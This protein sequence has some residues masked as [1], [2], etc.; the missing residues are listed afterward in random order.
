[1]QTQNPYSPPNSAATQE[2]SYGNPL[3]ARFSKQAVDRLYSRSCNVTSVASFT[4]II[5]LILLGQ[6]S[7]QLASSTRVDGFD[8]YIILFGFLGGFGAISAY[9]M[10]KR[11]RSGRIMGISCSSFALIL[12]PVGTIIGV[13]GLFG[14]IQAPILF[15]EKRI[16]HK[17]LKKEYQFRRAHR[18]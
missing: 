1:M 3:F 4:S 15:G 18:I 8:F 14:F 7:L 16:T 6:A 9:H 13:A 5:S 10:I 17:E 11:S 2:E 12:F